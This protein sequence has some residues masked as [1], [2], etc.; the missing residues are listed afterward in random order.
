M[1]PKSIQNFSLIHRTVLLAKKEN[2]L[3]TESQA[4][5]HVVLDALFKLQEDEIEEAITDDFYNVAK[6]ATPGKDRGVDAVQID[7]NANPPAIHI[8]SCKYTTDIQKT[9]SFFKSNR[10]GQDIVLPQAVDV[11]GPNASAGHKR[12]S[13]SKS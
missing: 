7:E 5:H 11:Q 1:K 4:F 8:F 10:G 2:S 13:Q 3:K 12:C 6:G 9:E